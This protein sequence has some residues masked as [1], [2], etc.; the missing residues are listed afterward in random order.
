MIYLIV[1]LDQ[2]IVTIGE[3]GNEQFHCSEVQFKV[4]S[5]YSSDLELLND[6]GNIL[7]KFFQHFFQCLDVFI[8]QYGKACCLSKTRNLPHIKW[9]ILTISTLTTASDACWGKTK[10][11]PIL[12]G[13]SVLLSEKACLGKIKSK[14]TCLWYILS[15]VW[16]LSP[17]FSLQVRVQC[18]SQFPLL[19]K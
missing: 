15:Q 13:K 6:I 2:F 8:E 9:Y 4:L 16:P 10:I 1:L 7:I 11:I 17:S 14:S 19:V 5:F 3:E 12:Q 18:G